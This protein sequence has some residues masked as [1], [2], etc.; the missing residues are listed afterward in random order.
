MKEWA[1]VTGASRGIGFGIAQYLASQGI[2]LILLAKHAA[3]LHQARRAIIANYPEC[4]I[5]VVAV[6]MASPETVDVVIGQLIKNCPAISLLVNCAGVLTP[7]ASALPASTIMSML[8]INLTSTLI[9]TN[10]VAEQMKR[11][12]AGH[13]FTVASLAGIESQSKLAVYAASKAALI[14]YNQS[15]YKALLPFNVN[16]TCLCPSV[17]NTDMTN[18]GRIPNE[19]KIQVDDVVSAIPFVLSLGKGALIPRLDIPC[20]PIVLEGLR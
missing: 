11:R 5:D 3:G 14:S 2:A 4:H 13:I 16:V 10:R 12:R 15:L 18:D 7:G 17:V 6:D 8:A 20:R 1:L 9:I 19:Q